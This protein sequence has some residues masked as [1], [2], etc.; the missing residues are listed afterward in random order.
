MIRPALVATYAVALVGV[1]AFCATQVHQAFVPDANLAAPTPFSVSL[2]APV[3]EA[4]EVVPTVE[5]TPI[6]APQVA[7]Y[8]T[9]D[10]QRMI[11]ARFGKD[12]PT[13]LC[14]AKAESGFDPRKTGWNNDDRHTHDRGVFQLNSYWQ[15]DTSDADAY[16]A[17][18]NIEAAY[19]IFK[20]W[21]NWRAWTTHSKCGV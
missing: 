18:K 15:A 21:G 2:P 4:A 9:G 8:G 5:P 6:T 13:A 20:N 10:V 7:S 14:I 19:R 17:V 1:S 3:V 11:V 12:A 16:D